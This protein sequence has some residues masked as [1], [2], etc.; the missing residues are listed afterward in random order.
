MTDD[1]DYEP[2]SISERDLG[3]LSRLER[4][5]LDAHFTD[6]DSIARLGSSEE[7]E[8]IA[9]NIELSHHQ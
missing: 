2:S 9:T 7:M 1:P 4:L 5:T 3:R 8:N 6:Q